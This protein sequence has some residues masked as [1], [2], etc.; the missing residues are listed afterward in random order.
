MNADILKGKWKQMVGGFK[1]KWADLTD[2]DWKHVDGG[3]LD[4]HSH[5]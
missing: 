5:P 2:D 3:A 1:Q 4:Q